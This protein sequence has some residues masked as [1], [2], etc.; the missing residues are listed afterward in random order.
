MIEHIGGG[1]S[2]RAEDIHDRPRKTAR[3]DIDHQFSDSPIIT[4]CSRILIYQ[5]QQ[6]HMLQIVS[7]T[8]IQVKVNLRFKIQ[9]ER[10]PMF[11][12]ARWIISMM[13]QS[14]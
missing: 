12:T 7:L 4:S 9:L 3:T 14:K 5:H 8:I 1:Q 13:G 6:K 11:P 2:Y 10:I